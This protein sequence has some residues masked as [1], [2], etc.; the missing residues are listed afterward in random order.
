MAD[1][2]VGNGAVTS[3]LPQEAPSAML[4]GRSSLRDVESSGVFDSTSS[5]YTSENYRRAVG[6]SYVLTMGVSGIVLV[7]LASSLRDMA[8][9]LDTSSVA[10]SGKIE[11]LPQARWV[12]LT[13]MVLCHSRHNPT[14]T[15]EYHAYRRDFVGGWSLA[16]EPAVS[17][18]VLLLLYLVLSLCFI[19]IVKILIVWRIHLFRL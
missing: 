19:Q 7:A 11:Y 14:A 13:T 1:G 3:K 18:S 16:V 5:K 15:K 8:I 4:S 2:D 10:V 12:P 17:R 6:A 9:A